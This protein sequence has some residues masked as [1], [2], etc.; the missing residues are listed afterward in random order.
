MAERKLILP[1]DPW[2]DATL[3][4]AMPPNVDGQHVNGICQILVEDGET[5]LL[6]WVDA[7]QLDEY[8]LGGEMEAIAEPDEAEG[9]LCL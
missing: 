2:F 3:A 9:Y 7:S 5:G 4:V 8:V 1:G 6:R